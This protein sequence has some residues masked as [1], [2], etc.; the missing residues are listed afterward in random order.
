[1]H[2]NTSQPFLLLVGVAVAGS[3]VWAFNER[4]IL[5]MYWFS[6]TAVGAPPAL[7]DK[8]N[9]GVLVRW[10][11]DYFTI[12]RIAPATF[13]IGEPR[14]NEV[15]GHTRTQWERPA[16]CLV[17]VHGLRCASWQGLRPLPARRALPLI[18]EEA[19]TRQLY[20]LRTR[21]IKLKEF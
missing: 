14:C 9:E 6:L 19:L 8:T 3:L 17:S 5:N 2:D 16:G 10:V 7:L 13:A 18:S 12:E 1:M 4:R 20:P 15:A 21:N 11:D